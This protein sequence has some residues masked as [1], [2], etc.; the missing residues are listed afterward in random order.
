MKI[1]ITGGTGFIGGHLAR[2]LSRQGVETVLISRKRDTRNDDLLNLPGSSIAA[3]GLSDVDALSRAFTGCNAVVHCAGINREYGEQTYQKVHIDG[4][5]NVVDAARTAGAGKVVLISFLRARPNC[6]SGY[7]ESKWAAE[8]IVRNSGLDY[9]II[10]EGITYG[11]GDHMISHLA[12]AAKRFPVFGLVGLRPQTIKPVAVEDLVRIL[13]AASTS[14]QLSRQTV[15]VVGPEEIS[16]KEALQRVARHTGSHVA[17][18][19]LPI[20]FHYGLAAVCERVMKIPLISKAQVRILAEGLTDPAPAAAL[21][22]PDLQPST[23][24]GNAQIA[25]ALAGLY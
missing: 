23:R 8:E 24:L 10:K 20:P 11:R 1:A 6:G 18:M 25:A 4:T 16:L 21:P 9:T 14:D 15:A 22:P 12:W 2:E 7:H 5:Q 17:T 19:P 13:V 3:V